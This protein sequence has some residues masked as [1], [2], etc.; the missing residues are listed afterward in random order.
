MTNLT[1]Y[2]KNKG[3]LNTYIP[4]QSKVTSEIDIRNLSYKPVNLIS[5]DIDN[6]LTLGTDNKLYIPEDTTDYLA[7]YLLAKG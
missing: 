7:Y 1:S 3:I 6:R 5:A 4:N 2:I